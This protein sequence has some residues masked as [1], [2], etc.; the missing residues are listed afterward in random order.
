MALQVFGADK[1]V[2]PKGE[3]PGNLLVYSAADKDFGGWVEGGARVSQV[4]ADLLTITALAK[5]KCESKR[6]KISQVSRLLH[7]RTGVISRRKSQEQLSP[8]T[9]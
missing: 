6:K 9:I 5:A 1:T 4:K 3:S 8:T 7:A 2:V